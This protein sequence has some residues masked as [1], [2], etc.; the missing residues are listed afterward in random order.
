MPVHVFDDGK[1]T[2]L[3]F[4]DV[5][6]LPAIFA[7]HDKSGFESL[8]NYRVDNNIVTV[9]QVSPQFT[10]RSGTNKVTSIFNNKAIHRLK[11][12]GNVRP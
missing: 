4:R 6:V 9:L 10:L 8:V 5:S 7:V 1:F 11:G 2:Y 3:Q 12:F